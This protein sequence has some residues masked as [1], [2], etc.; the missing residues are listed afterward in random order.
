MAIASPVLTL[1]AWSS[2]AA[3]AI[4]VLVGLFFLGAMFF[5]GGVPIG[6]A[7]AFVI[8]TLLAGPALIAAGCG[9]L[10]AGLRLMAGYAW[11]RS[12][13]EQFFWFVAA[14][15]ALYIAYNG[16]RIRGIELTEVVRG[17]IFYALTGAPSLAL[18]LLL[19]SDAVRQAI[20]R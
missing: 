6:G 18:A 3:G 12:A 20:T 1:A 5:A 13:L 14:S 16:A 7:G 9:V 15:T 17:G 19:R 10:F 11:A 2:V 8:L 4:I